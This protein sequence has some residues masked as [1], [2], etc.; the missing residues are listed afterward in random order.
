MM[1]MDTRTDFHA[2]VITIL[3]P[4]STERLPKFVLVILLTLSYTTLS[5]GCACIEFHTCPID[6]YAG[7]YSGFSLFVAVEKT[8]SAGFFA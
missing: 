3:C 1:A 6:G 8:D 5:Q 7:P 4:V 2:S